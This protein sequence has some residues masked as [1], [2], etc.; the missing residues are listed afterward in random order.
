[1][2]KNW[3]GYVE[4]PRTPVVTPDSGA[5]L[6]QVLAEAARSGQAVRLVGAGRTRRRIAAAGAG[7]DIARG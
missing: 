6:A 7:D 3:S 2:W 1:M 4:C 5:Q